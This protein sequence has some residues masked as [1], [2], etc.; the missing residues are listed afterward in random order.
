MKQ[1]VVQLVIG[2]SA[3]LVIAGALSVPLANFFY[4]VEPWDRTIFA[5][6]ALL[7]SA[8]GVLATWIPARRATRVDPLESLR[9]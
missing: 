8:T 1:S 3:G 7:L 4:Q 2:L 9:Q 5:V 6:I